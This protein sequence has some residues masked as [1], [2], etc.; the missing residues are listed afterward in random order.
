MDALEAMID[1]NGL[2][3][4]IDAVR[5]ICNLKSEHVATNWQDQ[6]LARAWEKNAVKLEKVLGRLEAT[7]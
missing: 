1:A 4:V 2:E 6:D 7:S 3:E 5:E